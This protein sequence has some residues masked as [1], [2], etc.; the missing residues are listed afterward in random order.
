M[1]KPLRSL[2]GLLDFDCAARWGSFKLAAQEL[3]KTPAAISLQVKQLEETLGFE[4]FVRHPRHITLTEKGQELAATVR[5]TLSEL[6]T[7][8]AALQGGDE[9][10]IL[11]LST[12]HSLAIKWLVPRIARFTALYPELD[13]RI[14]SSDQLADM[15]DGSTDI[16]LRTYNIVPGDPDMLFHDRLVAVY[17]PSLLAPG[18]TEIT[19]ADL[20]RYPL[21]HEFTT[22]TWI[23]L[24]RANNALK[25]NYQFSRSYTNFAVMVQSALA[26]QGIALVSHAI[27]SEDLRSGALK[28]VDCE[29]AP[30]DR[31]YRIIVARDKR[32]M[33]K[34]THFCDWLRDEVSAMQRGL[35]RC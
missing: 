4:L 21:L 13:I 35:N 25:G 8:V 23:A 30:Y 20:E 3:H 11:R 1:S 32:G 22:D 31:G 6:N 14:D 9:E 2:S 18:A 27:A 15:N 24:L 33:S 29:C 34:I 17:S 7:K 5:R 19:V 26:G 28:M 16:A 12:T 10:K